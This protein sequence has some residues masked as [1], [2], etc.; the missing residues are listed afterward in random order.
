MGGLVSL[1]LKRHHGH[2]NSSKGKHLISA[3]LEFRSL[4]HCHHSGKHGGMQADMVLKK[5][6]RVV[7]LDLQA[8]ER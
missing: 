4:V 1:S 3:G 2:S 7:H 6:L 5:E 8:A